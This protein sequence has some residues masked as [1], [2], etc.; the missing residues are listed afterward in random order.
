MGRNLSSTKTDLHSDI[1]KLL[2]TKQKKVLICYCINQD[3]DC[4]ESIRCEKGT[5]E[6][7]FRN[8]DKKAS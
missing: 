8:Q 5:C 3:Y 7:K 1:S 6:R 4:I 2:C